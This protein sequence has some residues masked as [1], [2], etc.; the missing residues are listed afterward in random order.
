MNIHKDPQFAAGSMSTDGNRPPD[1]KAFAE[2]Y[3]SPKDDHGGV[4]P[5]THD[6]ATMSTRNLSPNHRKGSH[7]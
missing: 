6:Y 5:G 3:Q 2:M 1:F 7:Y 4:L